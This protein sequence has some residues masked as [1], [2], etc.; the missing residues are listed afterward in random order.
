MCQVEKWLISKLWSEYW[1]KFSPIFWCHSKSG[2][3]FQLHPPYHMA[4]L[5]KS[6]KSSFEMNPDFGC[7]VLGS[8]WYSVEQSSV[9][10]KTWFYFI[11]LKMLLKCVDLHFLFSLVEIRSQLCLGLDC[12]WNDLLLQQIG[13]LHSHSLL[14][15]GGG[16]IFVSN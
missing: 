15:C 1:T 11:I 14:V 8:P 4:F 12:W 10:P 3:V 7:L 6:K 9:V 5:S 2:P 16:K 13:N